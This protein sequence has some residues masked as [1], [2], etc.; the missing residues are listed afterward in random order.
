MMQIIQG[1]L[2]GFDQL[3]NVILEK[4]KERVYSAKEGISEVPYGLYVIRGDNVFAEITVFKF[5]VL[6]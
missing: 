1:L 2:R 3:T 5:Y 4:S 6:L